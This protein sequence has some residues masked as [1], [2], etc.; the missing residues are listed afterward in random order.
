MSDKKRSIL[1]LAFLTV[2]LDMVGFSIVFPLFP[3]MLE[4]YVQVEGE[5]GM[6]GSLAQWLADLAG[7][8]SR[9]SVAVHAFFGGVLGSLYSL[10]QFLFAP[11]WGALSDRH[12]RRPVLLFT[13]AGTALSYVVW[14]FA[15]GFVVLVIARLVGG[16]MA[17]NISTISAAVA[18]SSTGKQRAHGMGMIGAGIGMGFVFGP[19]I[20]ALSASINWADPEAAWTLFAINPFSAAAACAFAM[21]VFNLVWAWRRFPETLPKEKRGTTERHTTRRPLHA[22]KQVN[23]PGVR[24]ATLCYFAFYLAFSAMEFTLTFLVTERLDYKPMDIGMM[25]VFIGFLM[26]LVQGGVVRRLAPKIGEVRMGATGMLLTIPG[27]L[28]TG[29]AQS[30]GALYAGLFFLAVGSALVMPSFSS[31]VSRYAP[32]ERQGLALGLFRSMGSL[33]RAA[34]PLLGGALFYGIASWGPYG[35]GAVV[36][37][38]PLFMALRLPDPPPSSEPAH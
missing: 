16:I 32:A 1:G 8:E 19:A 28:I 6:A 34:G 30:G 26:V 9:H 23:A 35:V 15:G 17:G 24:G 4:H 2:F 22:L 31:L 38:L 37:L 18:D 5:T 3:A 12:G 11:V 13:L 25:F 29:W 20:G 33:A 27:F 10:L 14:F 21:A 36:I 7:H